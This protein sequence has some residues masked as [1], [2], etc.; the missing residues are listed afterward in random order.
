M[1]TLL[2]DPTRR[3]MQMRAAQLPGVEWSRN[4]FQIPLRV[5][6]AETNGLV[7]AEQARQPPSHWAMGQ[8]GQQT[9]VIFTWAMEA[10]L[11]LTPA[12]GTIQIHFKSPQQ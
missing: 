12:A 5:S 11:C 9:R 2:M 10:C 3:N 4:A 8:E 7:L 6:I 1:R